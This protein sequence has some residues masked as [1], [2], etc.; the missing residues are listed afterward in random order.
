MGE[1]RITIEQHIAAPPEQ[2]W[3]TINDTRRFAEWVVN[4]LEVTRADS[5]VADAG[6]TYDERNRIAGPLTGTSRWVV[7]ASEPP[8]HTV[9][10]GEGIWLAGAMRLEMTVEPEGDATRYLHEFFFEPGLGPLGPLVNLALKPSIGRDMHR[11]VQTLR[12]LCERE[13][14]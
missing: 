13:A 14:R 11:S 12:E 1:T 7:A 9:H 4:T 2:V 5:D 8:R 3:A 6:V 10:T